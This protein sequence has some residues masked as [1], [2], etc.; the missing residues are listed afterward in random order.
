MRADQQRRAQERH[1][2][3]QHRHRGG[4]DLDEEAADRRAGDERG[5]P[6]GAE[7]AVG[8]D[9]AVAVDQGHE[10]RRVRGGEQH[11]PHPGQ[12]RHHEQLGQ[13]DHPEPVGDRQAEQHGRAQQVGEDQQTFAVRLPVHPGSEEQGEQVRRPDGG[14]QQADLGGR[15]GQRGDG[16]ERQG[17]F[18]DPV[19]ELRDRLAGPELVEAHDSSSG[20]DGQVVAQDADLAGAGRGVVAAV[21]RRAPAARRSGRRGW[22][23][24][25]A[26]SRTVV[27]DRPATRS[28]SAASC[29]RVSAIH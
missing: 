29:G 28:H 20:A 18:A 6:A 2:V 13:R 26:V 24:R 17:E 12:Q 23:A 4:E 15:G 1:G 8:V 27:L 14:G 19:A 21:R 9:V 11:L 10:E 7:L 25:P 5:G 22:T 16:D 3:D